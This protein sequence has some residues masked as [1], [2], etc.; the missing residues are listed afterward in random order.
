MEDQFILPVFLIVVAFLVVMGKMIQDIAFPILAG[1]ILLLLAIYLAI[2]GFWNL[3]NSF[4]LTSFV[5]ILA[6]LG[7]YMIISSGFKLVMGG[8]AKD[9]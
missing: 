7:G 2:N 6:G 9:V 1:Y 4:L 3:E 5:M 8:L